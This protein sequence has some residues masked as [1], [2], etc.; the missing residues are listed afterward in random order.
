MIIRG[1]AGKEIFTIEG[2][3][4]GACGG[5]VEGKRASRMHN[6]VVGGRLPLELEVEGR[7]EWRRRRRGGGLLSSGAGWRIDRVRNGLAQGFVSATYVSS[8]H[9]F[10]RSNRLQHSE[11]VSIYPDGILEWNCLRL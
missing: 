4:G 9:R 2:S 8:A 11:R 6:A 10:M 7:V 1:I 5:G 3:R